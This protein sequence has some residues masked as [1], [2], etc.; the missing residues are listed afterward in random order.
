MIFRPL[1]AADAQKARDFIVDS[2]LDEITQGFGGMGIRFDD[3]AT[4]RE[5]IGWSQTRTVVVLNDAQ[6]VI[7]GLAIFEKQAGAWGL[8]IVVARRQLTVQQRLQGFRDMMKWIA[9]RVPEDTPFFGV[10]ATGRR[11]DQAL[12]QTPLER[13]DL[14]DGRVKFVSTAGQM[15]VV[16]A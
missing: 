6:T 9:D 12:S 15:R 10:T 7:Q 13:I 2:G 11:L 14:G 3:L 1:T 16:F 8:A 4:L 5:Y